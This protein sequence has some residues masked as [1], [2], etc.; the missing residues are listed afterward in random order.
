MAY[1]M[2]CKYRLLEQ[3]CQD[4]GLNINELVAK[5]DVKPPRGHRNKCL[6]RSQKKSDNYVRMEEIE[7][8]GC[9]Y[10]IDRENNVYEQHTDTNI[11]ML[12]GKLST[13][14]R[15][16]VRIEQNAKYKFAN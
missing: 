10:L 2:C 13:D 6:S 3:V 16:I 14:R 9:S 7:V 15:T 4:Y 1:L 12:I 5:Y 8:M 11:V